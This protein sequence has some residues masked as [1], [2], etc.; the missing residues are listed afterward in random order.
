MVRYIADSDE[1]SPTLHEPASKAQLVLLVEGR[2]SQS[3]PLRGQVTLGRDK[4]NSIVVADQ[5]VSRHHASLASVGDAFIITDQGSANGTYLNGV[6][7]A[8]PTRLKDMD[9]ISVGDTHFRFSTTE[10]SAK[11]AIDPQPAAVLPGAVPQSP[12]QNA[13]VTLLNVGFPSGS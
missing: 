8:Q 11:A 9:H 5:K 13:P 12:A 3:F 6:L 10:S 1:D 7:L 4:S 2:A